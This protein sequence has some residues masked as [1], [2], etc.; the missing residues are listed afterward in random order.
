MSLQNQLAKEDYKEGDGQDE[1]HAESY[2]IFERTDEKFEDLE[3]LWRTK[4]RKEAQ[5]N[6]V[7]V[8]D[9]CMRCNKPY[10]KDVALVYIE[11]CGKSEKKFFHYKTRGGQ[12]DCAVCNSAEKSY[13][14]KH[15]LLKYLRTHCDDD[16]EQGN[17][18]PKVI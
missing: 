17:Y 8:L 7:N 12:H 5:N 15:L 1:S 18:V 6:K 2:E 14:T 4:F 10:S 16:L 11:N 3:R 13:K 9:I